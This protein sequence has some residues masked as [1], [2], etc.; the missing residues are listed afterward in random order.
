[1]EGRDFGRRIVGV[2]GTSGVLSC[3]RDVDDP[4]VGRDVRNAE[5]R[6]LSEECRLSDGNLL[7]VSLRNFS[8]SLRSST[9]MRHSTALF[10]SSRA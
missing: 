3:L 8:L 7:L 4:S 5:V 9:S 1:M 6:R 2:R 10:T